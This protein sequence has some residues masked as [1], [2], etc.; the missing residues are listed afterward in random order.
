MGRCD[1]GEVAA[2]AVEHRLPCVRGVN[3]AGSGARWMKQRIDFGIGAVAG[4]E[5]AVRK[6]PLEQSLR[7]RPRALVD[8]RPREHIAGCRERFSPPYV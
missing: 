6:H 2:H 7:G 4:R 5:A 3:P 8:I 1:A